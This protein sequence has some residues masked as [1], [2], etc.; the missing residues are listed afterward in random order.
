MFCVAVLLAFAST[1]HAQASE[2]F[3]LGADISWIPEREAPP[4]NTRY[5]HNGQVR[6]ILDIL[7]DHGFNYIRLRLFVDPTAEVPEDVA[8]GLTGGWRASPYST[9]G[10]CGLDSTIKFAQRIKAKGGFKFLLDFHYSDTW[11]DPGK[12]YKPVAWRGLN[13]AQLADTVRAY[14]RRSVQAFKDNGVLPDMIQ[15]GNE[16]INGMIHP[17]GRNFAQGGVGG[18]PS[19][20]RLVHAGI[21]G[22]KDVDT[23]ILIMMHTVSERNPSGWLTNLKTNLNQIETGFGNKI[24]V[25]GISYYPRWH[26]NL[27]SLQ[28]VLAA[29]VNNHSDIKISIVEYADLHREVND[30]VFALPANRRFGTFVWEPQEFDGDNSRPLFDWRNGRRETNAR[31]A[32]YPEMSKDYGN[33]DIT[34]ATRENSARPDLGQN[35]RGGFRVGHDGVIGYYSD[36]PGIVTVYNVQGR[37]VGRFDIRTPGTYDPANFLR[38]RSGTYII[39]IKPADNSRQAFSRRIVR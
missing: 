24:D 3:A 32:L 19:F 22:V 1:V 35:Q 14:T 27:D 16:V 25:F 37:A 28:R 9:R 33:D 12:Q 31:M 38:L 20:A 30:L 7:K 5:A 29:V 36:A 13:L 17:E 2:P 10:Y 23:S 34:T 21:S 4:S 39:A 26:G 15:V 8:Q 6:D 11:A 18:W